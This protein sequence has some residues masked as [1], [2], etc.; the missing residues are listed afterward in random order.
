MLSLLLACA[1]FV[2][3]HVFI[4][5]SPLRRE[6][7]ARIGERPYLAGFSVLSLGGMVWLVQAYRHAPLSPLWA[8]LPGMR[9]VGLVLTLIA[10]LLVV[11]G[12][13]TP[14]PTATG[15]ESQLDAAEPARGMLRITRH[16][17]LCGVALWAFTHVLLNGDAASLTLF[18]SMLLLATVGPALIDQKRRRAFGE[19]WQ[20]FAA[21]TSV[22]PFGA[23]A[24]GRNRLELGEIGLR[25]VAAALAVYV[26]ALVAHGSLFG[27]SPLP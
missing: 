13:T 8:P 18:G 25:R 26:A 10:F 12:L 3:I 11:G 6:V 21:V 16:P 2:G 27:V 24:A 23:I 1:F 5:G 17:F 7:V 22:V 20:R 19:K 4:S 14:S 15:G 9:T